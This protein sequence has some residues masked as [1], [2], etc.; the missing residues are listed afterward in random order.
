MPSQSETPP[1]FVDFLDS[2]DT[3]SLIIKGPPGSGK[4]TLAR[5]LCEL[6]RRSGPPILV[7]SRVS[8]PNRLG[9]FESASGLHVSV[10][11]PD[12]SVLGEKAFPGTPWI[13]RLVDR[14]IHGDDDLQRDENSPPSVVVARGDVIDLDAELPYIEA[15]KRHVKANWPRRSTVIVD[16]IDGMAKN[17]GIA[18]SRLVSAFQKDFVETG[19]ANVIFVAETPESSKLDYIG[20]GVVRLFTEQFEDRQVRILVLEKLRSVETRQ[21]RYVFTLHGGRFRSFQP[22]KDTQP[23]ALK[24]WNPVPDPDDLSVSWGYPALDRVFGGLTRGT[25]VTIEHA[26]GVSPIFVHHLIMGLVGNFVSQERGVAFIPAKRAT[27]AAWKALMKPLVGADDWSNRVLTLVPDESIDGVN[28][29]VTLKWESLEYR[30][31]GCEKP[32]LSLI[33]FDTLESLYGADALD[34]IYSHIG[35]VNQAGDIFVALTN[36][37]LISNQKLRSIAHV[38][39]RIENLNGCIVVFGEKPRTGLFHAGFSLEGGTPNAVLTPIV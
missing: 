1:E 16:S 8:N 37:L 30:L 9:P 14:V 27:S 2:N 15:V 32:F 11:K 3:Q 10:D 26:P 28:P 13:D 22:W 7:G 19:V 36:P 6:L 18:S 31:A 25:L 34:R 4:T 33:A 21:P 12:V 35:T 23:Q 5:E 24:P 39:V 29:H 20:D 38:H 17:L